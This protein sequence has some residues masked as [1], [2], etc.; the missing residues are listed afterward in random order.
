MNLHHFSALVL[1]AVFFFAISEDCAAQVGNRISLTDP[2]VS[3]EKDLQS[4]PNFSPDIVGSILKNRPFL[5]MTEFNSFLSKFLKKDQLTDVYKKL[6]IHLNLNTATAAEIQMI[7][8]VG[9]RMVHE[10]LEYRPYKNLDQFRR[11]IGKYVDDK[12]LS[13]LEQYVFLPINLNTASDQDILTIPGIGPRML[14]EFKEYRPYKNME[15][16]RREIGKYVDS[17]ELARLERYVTV[18]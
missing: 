1:I 13:R 18:N 9:T 12:E 11:E 17:K 10:F 16:F 14:S 6:F 5:S 15:Q 7:P 3:T 8:G 2:N 4:V